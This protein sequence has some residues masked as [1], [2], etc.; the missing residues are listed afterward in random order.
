M[1][2]TRPTYP[3]RLLLTE[4]EAAQVRPSDLVWFGGAPFVKTEAGWA[5]V[6]PAPVDDA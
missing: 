4:E 5:V 3:V 2:D 1:S 6:D